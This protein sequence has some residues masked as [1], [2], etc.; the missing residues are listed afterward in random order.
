MKERVRVFRQLSPARQKQKA[1]GHSQVRDNHLRRREM[2]KN[3]LAA[4]TDPF[5]ARALQLRRELFGLYVGRKSGSY[6][7]GGQNAAFM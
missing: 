6:Q 4:T 3:M 2:N 1:S 5:N 7:S